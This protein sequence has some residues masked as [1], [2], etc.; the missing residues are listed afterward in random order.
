MFSDHDMYKLY[1]FII[2]FIYIIMQIFLKKYANNKKKTLRK[3]IS[4]IE[5]KV[6][7]IHKAWT[8]RR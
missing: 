4:L 5:R 3:L 8:T 2:F 1:Y 6:I 7:Y